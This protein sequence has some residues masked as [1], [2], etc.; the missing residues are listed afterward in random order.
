MGASCVPGSRGALAA[1]GVVAGL[2]GAA[3]LVVEIALVRAAAPRFGQ[4]THVWANAIGVVLFALALG[5]AVGG[6]WARRD[7]RGVAVVPALLLAAAWLA[8]AARKVPEL[9]AALVPPDVSVDRPLPL[10]FWG[11]LALTAIVSGPPLVVLGAVP[12]VLVRR[13]AAEPG[14]A[15]AVVAAS[16]TL[17]GLLG[18]A[19]TGSLLVPA[20]GALGA[21]TVAVGAV[22]L[23]AVV[24]SATACPAPGRALAESPRAPDAPAGAGPS[25]L[26]RAAGLAVAALVGVAVTTAEFTAFRALAPVC[27]GTHRDVTA[28]I[29]AVLLALA[30]GNAVGGRMRSPAAD[31]RTVTAALVVAAV[32][33][34]FAPRV[35]REVARGAGA[36]VGALAG[37]G[38]AVGALGVASPVLVRARARATDAGRAA[39][40]VFAVGTVASLVGCYAT[41][42]WWLPDLGVSGTATLAAG[43]ALAAA[44]GAWVALRG[45][46]GDDAAAVLAPGT[47]ISRADA[48]APD[49]G[50]GRRRSRT[51]RLGTASFAVAVVVT[52]VCTPARPLRVDPG[53]L[54]EVETAY[55]TVRVIELDERVPVPGKV[56]L[57]G[58]ERDVRTR[59]LRFDEDATSYQSVRLLDADPSILT[60]GRYY[61]HLALGAWF[62]DA[63]W[64]RGTGAPRVLIVGYA[65]G[66]LHRVLAA[67]APADGPAPDV[68]G[69][70]LDPAVVRLSREHL[71]E[72]PS[73]L[74]LF[75][76]E[77]GRT[78]VDRLPADARF[79]LILVDAYQRTQY[80]PFQLSSREFFSACVRH[81]A[82]GGA[83]GLNVN[84]PSGLGGGL[85]AALAAT[86]ADA[87]GPRGGVWCV[88]NAQYSTNA[89]IWARREAAPP[90]VAG[91]V[92]ER[93]ATATFT[94]E[95]FLVRAPAGGTVLT[96]DRAPVERL[97]DAAL[98]PLEEAR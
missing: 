22:A 44:A 61:E 50:P 49:A 52:S 79:D 72:L 47:P 21:L 32:V 10:S 69:V 14:R 78:V 23:A 24:A 88:P 28:A 25:P 70:E 84:T 8:V 63:P 3:G 92:P 45:E 31:R 34:A 73:P 65:G 20:F 68:T 43:A 66:T 93:L 6:R 56:P 95:R 37:F 74:R 91:T 40:V 77:D 57:L 81:L 87:V 30:A 46:R 42:L 5:G 85:A 7:P 19:F 13:A 55:Q 59:F 27:G 71:G 35:T 96:D 86:M 67:V 1:D 51:Q 53:Q 60:A 29:A 33:L 16:G 18:C 82:P 4:G 39:G 58:T 62:T 38:V 9:A 75:E 11:S 90:R 64:A 54:V 26:A 36:F 2:L 83:I 17:G 80:V 89:A 94:L 76:G 15:T 41:P 98:L 48:R 97:S 12:P